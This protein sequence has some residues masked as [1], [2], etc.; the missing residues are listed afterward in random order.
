MYDWPVPFIVRATNMHAF[1]QLCPFIAYPC[2]HYN[3]DYPCVLS[4]IPADEDDEATITDQCPTQAHRPRS[5][6]MRELQY[7]KI[8]DQSAFLLTH[9][10]SFYDIAKYGRVFCLDVCVCGPL[11]DSLINKYPSGFLR[12]KSNRN[13]RMCVALCKQK[14][15]IQKAKMQS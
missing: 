3:T 10:W 7:S 13:H 11:L 5:R 12:S 9:F 6:C 14:L 15:D 1:L 2:L 8:S 4:F